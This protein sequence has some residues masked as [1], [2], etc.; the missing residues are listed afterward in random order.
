M[1]TRDQA[2]QIVE[3]ALSFSQFPETSAEISE[4]EKASIRFANNG[5][6]TSG[7]T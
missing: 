4:S 1:L 3:K 6:T 5:L 7:F 2:L